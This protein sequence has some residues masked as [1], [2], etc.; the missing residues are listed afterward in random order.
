MMPTDTGL[1]VPLP[2]CKPHLLHTL[3][4]LT[5]SLPHAARQLPYLS[6]RPSAKIDGRPLVFSKD[7]IGK[8]HLS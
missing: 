5:T 1:F 2:N 7:L 8:P 4:M 6:A 3:Y